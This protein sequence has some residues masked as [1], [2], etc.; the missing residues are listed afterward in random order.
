MWVGH[1]IFCRLH[2]DSSNEHSSNEHS[3]NENSSKTNS[4]NEHSSNVSIYR[5]N[6]HQI[7]QFIERR[8]IE[9]EDISKLP[10]I[11]LLSNLTKKIPDLFSG[12]DFFTSGLFLGLKLGL[13]VG[14]GGAGGPVR[15]QAGLTQSGNPNFN[16]KNRSW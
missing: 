13:P 15:P 16:P 1:I 2:D 14:L 4:S 9:S 6:I 12:P 7:Y 3:S 5:K 10:A 11:L 8:F